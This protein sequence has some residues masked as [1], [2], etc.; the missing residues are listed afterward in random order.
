MFDPWLLAGLIVCTWFASTLSGVAGFGGAL[1][2]LPVLSA[3]VG[4]QVAIPT[5]TIM[6]LLGN[7]SRV[8]FG[9]DYIDWPSVRTFLTGALPGAALG[10][11]FVAVLPS[12]W[13]TRAVGGAVIA[14]VLFRRL[15][16]NHPS[17][18]PS[19]PQL[20]RLGSGLTGLI[21]GSVGSAGPL[22]AAI[23]LNL[24]LPLSAYVASEA[25]TA[26]VMHSIKIIIY[27][28][29][30]LLDATALQLGSVLGV[31]MIIG[32][33]TGKHV[34]DRANATVLR[35]GIEAILIVVACTLLIR[36]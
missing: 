24:P 35:T 20:L 8:W 6:Q 29:A 27:H 33:W 18:S 30:T 14:M 21:S 5:L 7:L 25:V 22:G 32:S 1:M 17:S 10:S 36:V 26:V 2:L 11:L 3:V 16:S 23:F 13:V 4:V 28:Q 15:R 9:R 31:V 19:S 34:I 12:V